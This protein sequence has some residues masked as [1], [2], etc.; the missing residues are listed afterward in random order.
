VTVVEWLAENGHWDRDRF[1][2]LIPGVV[3]AQ[4][5]ESLEVS[6]DARRDVGMELLETACLARMALLSGHQPPREDDRAKEIR[7]LGP[8]RSVGKKAAATRPE[9]AVLV[10][11]AEDGVDK[12]VSDRPG[13]ADDVS[14]LIQFSNLMLIWAVASESTRQLD[15]ISRRIVAEFFQPRVTYPITVGGQD[16]RDASWSEAYHGAEWGTPT[17]PGKAASNAVGD[18]Y[19]AVLLAKQSRR[20]AAGQRSKD[21]GPLTVVDPCAGIGTDLLS[22]ADNVSRPERNSPGSQPAVRFVGFE[23]DNDRLLIARRRAFL[24]DLE[25]EFHHA[26]VLAEDRMAGLNVDLIVALS[27]PEVGGTDYDY[28]SSIKPHDSRWIY[29][30]PEGELAW[31]MQAI[32]H[33]AQG[34]RAVVKTSPEMTRTGGNSRI[35]RDLVGDGWLETLSMGPKED[36]WTLSQEP[37]R[38]SFEVSQRSAA[39]ET[40]SSEIQTSWLMQHWSADLHTLLLDQIERNPRQIW[41]QMHDAADRVKRA[42]RDLSTPLD[43]VEGNIIGMERLAENSQSISPATGAVGGPTSA[44]RIGELARA[45]YLEILSPNQWKPGAPRT[46]RSPRT[47]VELRDT[48]VV[49]HLDNGI[50]AMQWIPSISWTPKSFVLRV[51]NIEELNPAYLAYALAGSWNERIRVDQG[52]PRLVERLK[53]FEVPMLTPSDQAQAED[54]ILWIQILR[55]HAQELAQ[56]AQALETSLLNAIRFG[57][58]STNNPNAD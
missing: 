30:I 35:L 34:G 16:Y 13:L 27:P 10:G 7:N 51:R 58:V 48:D 38:R 6:P 36:L 46:D 24:A 37:G 2:R 53:E 50:R 47:P 29:G 21:S 5:A 15:R 14:E 44:L 11:A 18:A 45:G 22:M 17:G 28:K 31:I 23:S 49:V 25:I 40:T 54:A 20:S 12:E 56:R 4:L 57:A 19:A 39:G 42:A 8:L 33:L 1:L 52:R 3:L 32:T 55:N 9:W 43:A 41:G 26:D